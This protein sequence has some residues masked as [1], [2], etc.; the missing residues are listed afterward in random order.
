MTD[1]KKSQRE[2]LSI[3][4]WLK[5]KNGWIE[6]IS[7][8]FTNYNFIGDASVIINGSNKLAQEGK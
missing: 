4:V 6:T 3:P 1:E 8:S 7:L 2:K 5:I